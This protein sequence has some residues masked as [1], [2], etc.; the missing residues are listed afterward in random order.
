MGGKMQDICQKLDYTQKEAHD[1]HARLEA[2]EERLRSLRTA[3][4]LKE[5]HFNHLNNKVERTDWDAKFREVQNQL[6]D[7]HQQKTS[8]AEKLEVLSQ[9]LGM[10]E[11]AHDEFREHVGKIRGQLSGLGNGKAPADTGL[12]QDV[13]VLAQRLEE[14]ELRLDQVDANGE[15]AQ[16]NQDVVPRVMALVDTLKDV[17]P[18]VI[19]N[20]A[21]LRDVLER[22]ACLEGGARL[23]GARPE[24][25]Q[26]GGTAGAA[27]EDL[28]ARVTRVEADV[29]RLVAEVEGHGN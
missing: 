20:E 12:E 3:H 15:A 10:H 27:H 6:A 25:K 18:K 24:Y 7:M 11:A 14:A 29:R 4:E 13:S 19:D 23:S 28:S 5:Q 17:A 21:C 2:Q 1:V 22:V 8:H 9:Q 26:Q 16:Q